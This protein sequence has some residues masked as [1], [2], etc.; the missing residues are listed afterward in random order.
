MPGATLPSDAAG[1]L[2]TLSKR[3]EDLERPSR[4]P[5]REGAIDELRFS[6]PGAV[7]VSTS[8]PDESHIGGQLVGVICRLGTAGTSNTVVTV[9]R[10]GASLGTVTLASGE[11]RKV[12]YLGNIRIAAETDVVTVGVTTAG[13]GASGLTVKVRLRT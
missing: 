9:Y 5:G 13:A 7:S 11:T 10:N 1:Q 2:E 12:G 6:L 8:G 4:T 3:L